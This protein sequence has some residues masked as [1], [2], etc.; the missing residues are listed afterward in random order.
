MRATLL[1]WPLQVLFCSNCTHIVLCPHSWYVLMVVCTPKTI[2]D[3]GFITRTDEHL[4]S[5]I[6]REVIPDLNSPRDFTSLGG[7]R[8]PPVDDS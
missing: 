7:S 3:N 1:H 2:K 6:Q 8:F 4:T 5:Q